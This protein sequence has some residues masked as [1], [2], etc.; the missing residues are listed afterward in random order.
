MVNSLD[1]MQTTLIYP[2]LLGQL[3]A[4]YSPSLPYGLGPLA[5]FLRKNEVA[6]DL[7][8]TDALLR[9]SG[10]SDRKLQRLFQDLFIFYHNQTRAGYYSGI[11]EKGNDILAGKLLDLINIAR[12]DTPVGISILDS[13]QILSALLLAE[14]IKKEH[15]RPVIVGGPFVT[16]FSHLFFTKY[17]FIDYAIVGEG[18]VPLLKL[19]HA[20]YGKGKLED[21]PSLWYRNASKPVFTGRVFYNIEDQTC[22]DFDGLPLELY[23]I[24]RHED[25]VPLPYSLSRGCVNNCNFC[26][27][28]NI[29]GPWQT[30]SIKKVIQDITSLKERYKTDFWF[31]CSGFFHFLSL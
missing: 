2:P 22:P 1:K 18:E 16:E 9:K 17:N 25:K 21:V 30:K 4:D 20:I 27:Y 10:F 5:G 19:I 29:D 7:I 11:A 24:S 15:N 6:V 12:G 26:T 31:Y 8:D 3:N 23:K 14:K 13:A 28:K